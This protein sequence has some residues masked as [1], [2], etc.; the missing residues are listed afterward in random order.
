MSRITRLS[1]NKPK[2]RNPMPKALAK[3]LGNPFKERQVEKFPEGFHVAKRKIS[4][5]ELEQLVRHGKGVSEIARELGVTKGAVSKRLKKLN[6]AVSKDVALRSAPQVVERGLNAVEQLQKINK[7]ANEI[8]D[9]LM[10]WNRGDDEALRILECQVRKIRVKGQEIPVE[11]Y[12]MTDPRQ[13]ALRAMAEIRNQLKLQLEIFQALYDMQAVAEFQREVLHAIGE[14][15]P[16]VREKIIHRLQKA[17]A[18][19]ST[20]DFS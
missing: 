12:K 13:L 10:R 15:A 18:L 16:D 14:V 20:L 19:R 5:V 4:N 17:S 9:L 7:D 8:L 3:A 11:E 2:L 6:V 1:S